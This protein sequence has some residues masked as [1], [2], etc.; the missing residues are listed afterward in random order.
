MPAG[1]GTGRGAATATS[2]LTCARPP[3]TAPAMSR[4]P[5]SAPATSV[6]IGSAPRPSA[7]APRA[8]R[9]AFASPTGKEPAQRRRGER[10][11]TAGP[12]RRPSPTGPFP[13]TRT[14]TE[15]SPHP[16]PSPAGGSHLGRVPAR[17]FPRST[18]RGGH[19]HDTFSH[20]ISAVLRAPA[21]L[22]RPPWR[23][24]PCVFPPRAAPSG[25][26][27]GWSPAGRGGR[28]RPLAGRS[29]ACYTRFGVGQGQGLGKGQGF[30]LPLK[31]V[32]PYGCVMEGVR[33]PPGELPMKPK[34]L[35]GS[36][37]WDSQPPLETQRPHHALARDGTRMHQ[38]PLLSIF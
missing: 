31:R 2:A 20:S 22:P 23:D 17:L 3:P 26:R 1:A 18:G 9:P 33:V 37:P 34:H 8:A 14:D 13:R 4:P 30:T 19:G 10:P 12:E 16:T 32:D 21:A 38:T 6:P 15:R 36:G 24:R 29:P 25:S 7:A 35:R 5:S 27:R 11:P 28:E